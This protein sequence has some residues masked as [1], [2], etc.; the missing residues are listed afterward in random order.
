MDYAKELGR[1]LV[2]IIRNLNPEQQKRIADAILDIAEEEIDN[3]W[4]QWSLKKL[5][6]LLDIP[7][8]GT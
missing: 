1:I 3:K 6:A 4:V 7:E 2:D 5:R 8:F